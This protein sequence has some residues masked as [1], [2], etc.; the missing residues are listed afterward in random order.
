MTLEP[1]TV[2]LQDTLS[3]FETP[4]GVGTALRSD[5]EKECY[6]SLRLPFR[7]A[8]YPVLN[9]TVESSGSKERHS[10]AWDAVQAP[11]GAAVSKATKGT[12][13]VS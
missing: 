7:A 1:L 10:Q 5:M 4:I 3:I 2:M 8:W 13:A 11:T 6:T 9:S 12:L